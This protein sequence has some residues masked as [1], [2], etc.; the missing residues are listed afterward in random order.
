MADLYKSRLLDKLRGLQRKEE[1]INGLLEAVDIKLH[2]MGYYIEKDSSDLKSGT[3]PN[4]GIC[5]NGKLSFRGKQKAE[6]YFN[7]IDSDKDGFVNYE[8][9]RGKLW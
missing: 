5:I 2:D 8:D 7:A 9:L 1:E 4:N 3:A 6:E